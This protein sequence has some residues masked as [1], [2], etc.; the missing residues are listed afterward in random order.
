MSLLNLHQGDLLWAT[1]GATEANSG[2]EITALCPGLH[3]CLHNVEALFSVQQRLGLRDHSN[4]E[5]DTCM[6]S[7]TMEKKL[8]TA[9]RLYRS[10]R[11]LNL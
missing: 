11:F 9:T 7:N 8:D 5:S 3:S 2:H 4:C 10:Q 1:Q 6:G